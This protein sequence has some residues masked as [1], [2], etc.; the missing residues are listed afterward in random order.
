MRAWPSMS[1]APVSVVLGGVRAALKWHRGRRRRSDPAFDRTRLREAI[2]AGASVEIDLNPMADGGFAVLHDPTLD[3]ETTGTGPVAHADAALLGQLRRRTE[4]GAVTTEPVDTLGEL[5]RDLASRAVV[6]GALLQLDLKCG[7]GDLT[8]DHIA[9]FATDVAPLRAHLILSGGDVAAVRRL[10]QGSGIA[11]GYDPC[12][13]GA[14][15]VQARAGHFGGFAD[16]ALEAMPEARFIY[17]D[18]RLIAAADGVGVNIVAPFRAAG[19]SVD[20]YTVTAAEP[21]QVAAARRAIALGADQ[22]T[23]DDPEGLQRALAS[24]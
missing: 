4:D 10:A 6:S 16:G 12:H 13:E 24:P 1:D 5:V 20:A 21:A 3:R 11:T 2:A 17:L 22:I 15:L 23:T 19:K 14:H 7:D 18:L 8:P 9:C